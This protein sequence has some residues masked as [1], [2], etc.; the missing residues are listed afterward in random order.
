MVWFPEFNLDKNV[1]VFLFIYFIIFI[2][3]KSIYTYN[4]YYKAINKMKPRIEKLEPPSI[5]L[6]PLKAL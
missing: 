2:F 5:F 3:L 4:I 1:G 6:K